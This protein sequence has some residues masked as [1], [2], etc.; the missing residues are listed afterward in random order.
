[1]GNNT[2]TTVNEKKT[3]KSWTLFYKATFTCTHFFT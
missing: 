1:M 3:E 2:H